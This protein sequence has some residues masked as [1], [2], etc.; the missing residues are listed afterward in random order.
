MPDVLESRL[1]KNGPQPSSRN[2]VTPLIDG[3]SGEHA[4]GDGVQWIV[5][6]HDDAAIG[7][8]DS[9]DLDQVLHVM[10]GVD[11]VIDAECERGIE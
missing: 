11:V 8:H 4:P 7:A 3:R 9:P 6:E 5:L 10:G 1:G 2:E